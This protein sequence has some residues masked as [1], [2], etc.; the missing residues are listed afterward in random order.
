MK[1]RRESNAEHQNSL[2]IFLL[3]S[4]FS[5]CFLSQG[6]ANI[7]RQPS[8]PSPSVARCRQSWTLMTLISLASLLAR[9]RMVPYTKEI[10]GISMLPSCSF[11]PLDL[12]PL[13]A[14]SCPSHAHSP[15][16]PLRLFTS[17]SNLIAF[18]EDRL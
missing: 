17:S 9:A 11:P 10:I 5:S 4:A 15:C 3:P 8:Y 2:F 13:L 12:S 18:A 6:K 7:S 1:E 14:D 16:L